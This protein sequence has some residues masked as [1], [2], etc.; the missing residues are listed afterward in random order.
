M[1]QWDELVARRVEHKNCATVYIPKFTW[2]T[3]TEDGQAYAIN[4]YKEPYVEQGYEHFAI[5]VIADELFDDGGDKLV[6]TENLKIAPHI[7]FARNH[8]NM[9][10]M[11]ANTAT[12]Q[13][14][15]ER[16]I[17]IRLLCRYATKAGRLIDKTAPEGWQNV[18]SANLIGIGQCAWHYQDSEAALFADL[19][20]YDGEFNG[21]TTLDKYERILVG[22]RK[23]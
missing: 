8:V 2:D 14:Y 10:I 12:S 7:E 17:L 20:E 16:N 13:A 6:Y 18:V 23:R 3:L 1:A 21:H 11:A 22:A 9:H 15:A 19:P 5:M 4:H